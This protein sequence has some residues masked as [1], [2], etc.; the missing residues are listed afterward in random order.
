MLENLAGPTGIFA[1]QCVD[2]A[3]PGQHTWTDILKVA[4]KN[5]YPR[6]EGALLDMVGR[7][8]FDAP[9]FARCPVDE[10]IT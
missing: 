7:L 1:R 10:P 2:L 8:R 4:D 9:P 3:Q 6:H 5:K